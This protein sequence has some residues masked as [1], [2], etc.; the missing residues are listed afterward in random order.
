MLKSTHSL[1]NQFQ[2]FNYRDNLMNSFHLGKDPRTIKF[3]LEFV[4]W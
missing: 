1:G 4:V 3:F 2:S